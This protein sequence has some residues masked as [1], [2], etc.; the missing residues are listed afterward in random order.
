M[1]TNLLTTRV[2]R[3]G[4]AEEDVVFRATGEVDLNTG[5]ELDAELA[6]LAAQPGVTGV[7]CDLTGVGFFGSVGLTVLLAACDR[8]R[9]VVVAGPGTAAHRTL[10]VSGVLEALPVVDTVADGLLALAR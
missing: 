5:A 7:V 3:V 8:G 2:L 1:R 10:L 4:H 6:E 9:F